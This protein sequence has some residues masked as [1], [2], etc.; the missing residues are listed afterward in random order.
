[1]KATE[2]NYLKF[3]QGTKQF[4]VPI[5]QRTYSW[6]LKQCE[7][8]WN[9]IVRVAE[10]DEIPAHFIGSIVYIESGLYQVTSVAQL[11]VIDGQQRLTTLSLLLSAISESLNEDESTGGLTKSKIKNYYMLNNEEE[12]DLAYKLKL[13]QT[14]RDTLWR[15]IEN[16]TLPNEVSLR[17]QENYK[18]FINKIKNG[19]IPLD[20]LIKGIQKLV[21]VDISL[22]RDHDN[23]QLIFESLNSTGLDLSQ[24][25]LI[26]NYI[27]M[28]LEP[29]E[30]RHLYETYWYLMEQE[31]GQAHYAKYLD[32]FMRDYLTLKHESGAIPTVVMIYEAFK[33][34]VNQT[35]APIE[36]IVKDIHKYSKHYTN[37]LMQNG[38]QADINEVLTDISILKV[39]V[40][41]PLL[42]EV[43]NDYQNGILEKSDLIKILRMIESYVFR[44]A[45][46][47]IPTNSLNKT[48][49][50]FTRSKVDKNNYLESFTAK[51][52]LLDSYR[53]FPSNEEFTQSLLT[54][55]VYNF[56]NRNYILRK[57]EN[58]DRKEKVQVDNYTIEHIMPQ[59]EN[60]SAEWRRDLGN[61]WQSVQERYLHT[62]GNLSLTGYNSELSDR[63]FLEKRN[64]KGGFA[65]SP[66]RLNKS[67]AD[68]Q[69]WNEESIINRTTTL[70]K[71]AIKIWTIP[72]L[73]ED[74]LAQYRIEPEKKRKAVYSI[75]DH[76]EYLQGEMLELFQLLRRRILYIDSTVKEE[77]KKLYIAYK[78]TTNFVDIIPQKSR[79]RLSLNMNFDEINDPQGICKDVTNL[80]RWGNGDVEVG[81]KRS[82][83]I[84]YV[85]F[86]IEQ[87]FDVHSEDIG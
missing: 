2:V 41:F 28:G 8:L 62:I 30:Q 64:M 59:N 61:D 80:G 56:R 39:D 81:F 11:L 36:D 4:I 86:L 38:D 55:D 77:F 23:P 66:I 29:E 19:G 31:F 57:L 63:P 35:T 16:T 14:D 34:Y 65:D 18:Y 67:L 84:D 82:T 45:I 42:L 47:G 50:T 17:V 13:T 21:I 74:V 20:N 54:R 83:E 85:M 33:K 69:V 26:R 6:T 10:K 7:Q 24:A 72:E 70:G 25:D 53:R 76:A 9:D 3:L 73:M 78:T 22:D 27:L 44:R 49:A 40:S 60:L 37:L 79:L 46:C 48:F 87:S 15:I 68:L 12:G 32:W 52:L 43:L 58:F 75:E 5:Y 1:M 51:L 71:Q